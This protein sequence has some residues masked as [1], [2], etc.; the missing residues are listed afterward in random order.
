MKEALLVIWQ[1]VD[2][3]QKYRIGK[4]CYDHK[5]NNYEFTYAYDV[6]RRGLSEAQKAGFN[7]IF[8]F[9]LSQKTY[10]SKDLFHFFNKRLPNPKRSDYGKLLELFDLDEN[11]SKMEF[12]RKTKGRLATDCYELFSPIIQ[13][14][15][16]TFQL[17][18]F[19]EG[20]QYYEGEVLLGNL[21]V[22]DELKLERDLGNEVDEFAVKVLTVNGQKLGFVAAVYSEFMA[23]VLDAKEDYQILIS[24]LY[25][26]A[27]PQMKVLVN[28]TGES[29][30]RNRRL[31]N[32]NSK[33]EKEELVLV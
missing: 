32:S 15:N 16:N 8:E 21:S 13:N 10:Y 17:E 20:W 3:R 1:N 24:K 30:F 6:K 31:I 33:F 14:E 26:Q 4:L 2:T 12:L 7:G 28:I 25:P 5:T 19:I 9:D 23:E 22:G 27:I 29:T 18:S 11:S